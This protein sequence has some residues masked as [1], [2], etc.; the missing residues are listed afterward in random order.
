MLTVTFDEVEAAL[1]AVNAPFAAAEAHGALCGSLVTDGSLTADGWLAE[2]MPRP[3]VG[4][5]A[6]HSRNLLETLFTE[7]RG[8]LGGQELEFEPVL[9][10]DDAPL[11]A[12][13]AALAAWC[14]GFLYGFG[15][16]DRY[17]G[18]AFS[19]E[20]SEV[21]KDFGEISRAIVDADEPEE[22]S[23]ASYVELVE[24]LRAGTQLTYEELA[25]A[26]QPPTY[27]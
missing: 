26:R 24:Y 4:E 16:R 9:P 17:G 22:S 1:A 12:R 21:L 11:E 13:V 3:P 19:D 6:L 27:S 14:G 10:D 25:A 20:V 18:A 2:L 7:T 23:E 5:H 15:V 8:A